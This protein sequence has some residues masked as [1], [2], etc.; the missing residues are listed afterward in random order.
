MSYVLFVGFSLE[1]G[2]ERNCNLLALSLGFEVPLV[3]GF[4]FNEPRLIDVHIEELGHSVGESVDVCCEW[5]TEGKE[6]RTR[7]AHKDAVKPCLEEGG[8]DVSKFGAQ[9]ERGNF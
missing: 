1:R 7:A 4:A 6:G 8:F 5:F 9:F 3:G 2:G